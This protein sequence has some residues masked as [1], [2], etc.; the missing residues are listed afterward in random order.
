MAT[1]FQKKLEELRADPE[2]QKTLK[3][4]Q[5]ELGTYRSTMHRWRTGFMKPDRKM[6]SLIIQFFEGE[7]NY[8]DLYE[9]LPND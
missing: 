3:K 8:Q 1:K 6:A 7:I 5:E 9:D 4:L 2:G